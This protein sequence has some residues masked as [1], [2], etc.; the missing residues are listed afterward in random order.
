MTFTD[1]TRK[2][3]TIKTTIGSEFDI[4]DSNVIVEI[5]KHNFFEI[6]AFESFFFFFNF[7]AI[8]CFISI[9]YMLQTPKL[10]H[11]HLVDL[12]SRQLCKNISPYFPSWQ[13][14]FRLSCYQKEGLNNDYRKSDLMI[15]ESRLD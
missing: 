12:F 7:F 6:A 15:N 13:K 8:F 3:G 4:E 10:F 1:H 14:C 5:L 2:A 9:L 11:K